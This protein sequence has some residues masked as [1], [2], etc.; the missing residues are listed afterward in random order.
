MS[1]EKTGGLYVTIARMAA[2]AAIDGSANRHPTNALGER[3]RKVD[4]I[5]EDNDSPLSLWLKSAAPDCELMPLKQVGST[6]K[7]TVT[8]GQVADFLDTTEEKLLYIK[9]QTLGAVAWYYNGDP[10]I[11]GRIWGINPADS[12]IY[13][14]DELDL[15]RFDER[16]SM[17]QR[18]FR[19]PSDED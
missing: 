15:E 7:R 2:K 3:A 14:R 16:L 9:R 11:S 13:Y 1:K 6:A 18:H 10:E 19:M 12:K 4:S 17:I 5:S 8:L